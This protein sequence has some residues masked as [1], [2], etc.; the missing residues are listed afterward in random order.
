MSLRRRK[1]WHAPFLDKLFDFRLLDFVV[2][3]RHGRHDLVIGIG[4]IAAACRKR[5]FW[6]V[7][8]RG[9]FVHVHHLHAYPG[10]R[11]HDQ[12]CHDRLLGGTGSDIMFAY[13]VEP[14]PGTRTVVLGN[15]KGN[16]P[17]HI[18]EDGHLVLQMSGVFHADLR[19]ATAAYDHDVAVNTRFHE[20]RRIDDGVNG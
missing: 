5:N 13:R 16:S 7:Q 14:N 18:F 11:L 8:F 4:R 3:R 2:E 19:L 20:R 12:G 15:Q 10:K 17:Q 9:V 6:V 1:T